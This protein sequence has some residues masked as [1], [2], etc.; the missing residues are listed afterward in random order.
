MINNLPKSPPP[1]WLMDI[2]AESTDSMIP[3]Q[4][5]LTDSFYY[6]SSGFDGDPIAYLSGN[7]YSFIYVDY[8]FDRKDLDNKLNHS[9][10]LGYHLILSIDVN[11]SD[12]TPKGWSAVSPSTDDGDPNKHG[13][14]IKQPFAKWMVFQRNDNLD[15][16]HGAK[17]FSL[18]YLCADGVAA[19]QALYSSNKCTPLAVAI[20]QPG[21]GFGMNWTNF[22]DPNAIFA[23]TIFNSPYG[24]PK[25]LLYG[26]QGGKNAYKETCWPQYPVNLCFLGNTSIGVWQ[27]KI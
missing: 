3:I 15:D 11:E 17:R 2:N 24:T 5:L 16:N 12:L 25:Y 26:G 4:K 1:D 6:P 9:G 13:N 10:F 18:L 7:F 23:R 19:Y 21:T 8:G 14:W 22:T 27:K 20:I